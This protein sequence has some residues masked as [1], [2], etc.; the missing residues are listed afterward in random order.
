MSIS[1]VVPIK[2]AVIESIF[3]NNKVMKNGLYLVLVNIT[4]IVVEFSVYETGQFSIE[5]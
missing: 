5:I 4:F 2:C 3:L 1:Q